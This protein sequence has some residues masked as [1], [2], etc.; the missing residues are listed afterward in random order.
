VL[1]TTNDIIYSSN[2]LEIKKQLCRLHNYKLHQ[3]ILH[4]NDMLLNDDMTLQKLV[5][6]LSGN[7]PYKRGN[8]Q[9]VEYL[10]TLQSDAS[11]VR[12]F[13]ER[14]GKYSIQIHL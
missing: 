1:L 11:P 12:E 8:K 10:Q 13:K 3:C 9:V 7:E 4:L 2:I 5:A 14:K 6:Q